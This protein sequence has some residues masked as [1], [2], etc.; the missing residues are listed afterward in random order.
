MLKRKDFQKILEGSPYYQEEEP[1][2]LQLKRRGRAKCSLSGKEGC[3]AEVLFLS[4]ENLYLRKA[5]LDKQKIIGTYNQRRI[6][7][8]G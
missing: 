8:R 1:W 5:T 3:L 2:E 7:V 4:R 6:C